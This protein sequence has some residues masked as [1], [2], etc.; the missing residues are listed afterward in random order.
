[1]TPPPI[2]T[3]IGV[4][5][6]GRNEG[7]RLRA[8]LCSLPNNIDLSIYVDSGSSDDSLEIARLLG[9]ESVLLDISR[10]FTAARARNA[11][12][13]RL[14]ELA[15]AV[16]L[17]QFVDG[18][19]EIAEGWIESAAA[20]LR[21]HEDV[22]V[23]CG[24]RREREP[25]RN[26]YHR[27]ADMEWNSLPGQARSC[28]GDA[29]MRVAALQ[30]VGGYRD[31]LIA[32][33]E[34]ELCVRLRQAGWKVWRLDHD[35]T[36]HDV[37]MTSFRQWWRRAIRAGHA[38]TEVAAL[39][40]TPPERQRLKK[41]CSIWFWAIFP[42]AMLALAWPTGGYSVLLLL[43][44]LLLLY[45]KI[46]SYRRRSH[47]DSF[48]NGSLYAVACIVANWPQAWGSARYLWSRLNGRRTELIEY[49]E[50]IS[51]LQSQAQNRPVSQSHA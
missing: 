19:C 29:L 2:T 28:G 34:P 24:R 26:W 43:A 36:L 51:A 11:G 30:E 41:V 45:A 39:H 46:V 25:Q 32:G 22:A 7:E 14:L 12:L 31:S 44:L 17:V 20:F 50:S 49:G 16:E 38:Y 13:R 27:L 15:P 40:S 8:C 6:I 5:A 9:V 48:A 1:M 35:M 47:G 33:E 18:D 37:R 42:V 4:V 3:S 23:V 21:A 10:G